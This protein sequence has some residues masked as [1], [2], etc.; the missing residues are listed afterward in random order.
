MKLV[1]GES[2]KRVAR[3]P[4]FLALTGKPEGAIREARRA[5]EIDPSS[6]NAVT[7]RAFPRPL[8]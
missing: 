8:R 4:V 6:V 1:A 2:K 7:L 5:V 3:H